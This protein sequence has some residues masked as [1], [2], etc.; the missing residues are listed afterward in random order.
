MPT[1][2]PTMQNIRPF[3]VESNRISNEITQQ[4]SDLHLTQLNEEM[5]QRPAGEMDCASVLSNAASST[6]WN[7][8]GYNVSSGKAVLSNAGNSSQDKMRKETIPIDDSATT[9]LL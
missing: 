7:S 2:K 3:R 1:N 8:S 9:N 5:Q 6:A 4:L